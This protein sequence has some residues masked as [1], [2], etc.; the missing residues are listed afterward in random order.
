MNKDLIEKLKHNL[1]K[2]QLLTTEQREVFTEVRVENC[3]FL[4]N[5]GFWVYCEKGTPFKRQGRYRIR[6]GYQQEPDTERCEVKV[7][8][9][10]L[11][12]TTVKMWPRLTYMRS[13]RRYNNL[14]E[15]LDDPDYAGC[16]DKNGTLMAMRE[17]F[18]DS[19]APLDIPKF[20]LF[21]KG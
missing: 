1:T 11:S 6:S 9:A 5:N 8:E 18:E 19:N 14:H 2:H 10:N 20:V 13:G 21:R 17:G 12:D 7:L 3:E 15:A 4:A 16:E